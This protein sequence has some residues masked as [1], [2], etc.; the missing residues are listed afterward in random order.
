MLCVLFGKEMDLVFFLLVDYVFVDMYYDG[1]YG[2]LGMMGNWME[3][4]WLCECFMKVMWV[5]VGG[6]KLEN[7]VEVFKVSGMMFVDV[8]SGIEVLLGVKDYVKLKVFMDVI[9]VVIG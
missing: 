5:F 4:L 3:F 2:G 7:I 9:W 6:L 8:N 1:G